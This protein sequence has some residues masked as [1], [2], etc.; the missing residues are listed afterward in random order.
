MFGPGLAL[1]FVKDAW[2]KIRQGNP[3]LSQMAQNEDGLCRS[4]WVQNTGKLED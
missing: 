2:P 4:D 1:V 3:A